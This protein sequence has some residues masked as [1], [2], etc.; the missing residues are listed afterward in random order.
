MPEDFRLRKLAALRAKG[1]EPYPLRFQ[2][3]HSAQAALDHFDA[4]SASQETVR[5]AGRILTMRK[6]GK[7]AFAHVE[8]ASGRIQLYLRLNILGEDSYAT[9]VDLYDLGDIVGAE[10]VLFR[11]RTGE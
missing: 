9:V 5:L 10:G 3:T 2:R 4:L 8:D 6:M 11:T 7:V 1:I